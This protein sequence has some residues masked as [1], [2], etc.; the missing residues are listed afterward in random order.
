MQFKLKIFFPIGAFYPSQIGGPCNTLYWHTYELNKH[1][2]KIDVVTTTI[3]IKEG[4]VKKNVS[5][6]NECGTVFYGEGNGRSINIIKKALKSTRSADIIHLNSLFSFISIVVFSYAKIFYKNKPIV[7][8]VRGELNERALIYSKWW[9]KIILFFYRLFS[10]NIVFHGTSNQEVKDI[11]SHFKNSKVI[12]IP[13]LIKPSDRIFQDGIKK[14]LLFVGRIH[15]IKAIH[16]IIEGLSLSE[17]FLNSDFKFIIIGNYEDRYKYYYEELILL[18]EAKDLKD[19]IEFRG[20]LEGFEKER[21]YAESYATLLMSETENFGN[22]VL[23]SLNQGTPVITSKGTPWS[24]LEE[25]NCGYSISNEPCIIAKI[26]DLSIDLEEDQY[27]K[28]RKNAIQLVED[29]FNI[30]SQIFRWLIQY[31]ALNNPNSI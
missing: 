6:D 15:P 23:E 10:R 2:V 16:K 18:I 28:M 30:N 11:Y 5:Y 27:L 9:K 7:W 26:I 4:L 19:K 24:I 3:G 21:I 12:Q 31:K 29:K 8:S 14:N 13:N 17:N 25:F 20:H 22:V 1:A